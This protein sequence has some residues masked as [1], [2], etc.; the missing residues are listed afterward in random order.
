M[1]VDIDIVDQWISKLDGKTGTCTATHSDSTT[2]SGTAQVLWSSGV[3]TLICSYTPQAN[4][5]LTNISYII[6][7]NEGNIT[8]S[9]SGVNYPVIGGYNHAVI[10]TVKYLRQ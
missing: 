1:Y 9:I 7:T 4:N 8:L 6:T 2:A 3:L 5:T 10:V